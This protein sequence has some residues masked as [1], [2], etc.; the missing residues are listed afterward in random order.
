MRT[1]DFEDCDSSTLVDAR[2]HVAHLRRLLAPVI[3]GDVAGALAYLAGAIDE[4]LRA[5]GMLGQRSNMQ[6]ALFADDE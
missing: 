1:Y 3:P 5:R 2:Y 6:L 4:E